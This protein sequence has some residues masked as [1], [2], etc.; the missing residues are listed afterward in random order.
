[1]GTEISWSTNDELDFLDNIGTFA[2]IPGNPLK[3]LRGYLKGAA[4]RANWGSMDE[5]I[6]IAHATKRIKELSKRR[7]L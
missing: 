7:T 2:L 6:V 4:Q 1:M 3:L 5:D